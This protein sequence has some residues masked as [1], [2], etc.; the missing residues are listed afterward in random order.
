[1]IFLLKIDFVIQYLGG[2]AHVQTNQHPESALIGCLMRAF[3]PGLGIHFTRLDFATI[4][5]RPETVSSF[6]FLS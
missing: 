1:M 5:P 6:L 4:G 2:I 3:P